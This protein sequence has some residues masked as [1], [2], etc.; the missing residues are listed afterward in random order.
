MRVVVQ[1]VLSASVRVEGSEVAS[2]GRGMLVLAG[3]G[4]GD[5][6]ATA[7]RMAVKVANLRIFDDDE[8]RINVSCA[9]VGGAV[10]AVSQFT[11][12]GDLRRG[13]RPSFTAAAEPS[14]AK[15]LYER[16]CEAIEASG[17]RCERGVFGADMAVSLVNDGPVTIVLDSADLDGPRRA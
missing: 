10:L 11:L 7:Q 1:R 16:F 9:T 15:D 14:A 5:N 2:I 4:A 17:L 3:I 6:H 13:N 8:D 12:F